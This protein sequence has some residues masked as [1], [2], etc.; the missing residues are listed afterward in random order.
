[1]SAL[2]V[3]SGILLAA[4]ALAVLSGGVGLLRFPDFYTRIHAVGVTESAGAG[5]ILLGLLLRSPDWSTAV[6]L[7]IILL[8]LTLT[9]PTATHVLAHAARRDGLRIWQE[10]DRRR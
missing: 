4:G 7:M 8:F 5:L 6:R 3:V 9:S 10:G 2:D 1:M